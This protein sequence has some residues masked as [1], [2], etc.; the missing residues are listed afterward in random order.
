MIRDLTEQEKWVLEQVKQGEW[1]DLKKRFGESEENRYLSARFLEDLLTDEITVG[2][3]KFQPHRRG[4]KIAHAVLADPLDLENAEVAH[5]VSLNSCIFQKKVNCRD[6]HFT[7]HLFLNDSQF[8]QEAD[9]HRVNVKMNFFFQGAIFQGP[10]DF[11]GADIGRHFSAT[12]AQF[13]GQGPDNKANLNG[14]K[15]GVHAFFNGAVF[16]GPVDFGGADIGGQFFAEGAQFQGQG[17]ENEANFNAM[18]VGQSAF[19]SKAVFQGP[20]DFGNTDIKRQFSADGTQFKG[21]GEDN[22]ANFNAMKVGQSAFFDNAT[23]QGPVDFTTADIDGQFNADGA[24]FQGQGPDNEANFNGVRVGDMVFFDGASFKAG[25]TL[26][27]A[28]VLDLMI[29]YLAEPLPSLSLERTVVSR[30]LALNDITIRTLSASHLEVKVKAAFEGVG[31]HEEADLRD[32]S[33]SVLHLH[34]VT[35][36]QDPEAVLLEGLTYQAVSAGEDPG[37]W[38][39]LLDWLEHSRFN[40]QNYTQ[41]EGYFARCGHQGR[42]DQVFI[43]GKRRAANRLT[44]WKKWFTKILWGG[45]AGYGRKPWQVLYVIVPL[46]VL[47]SVLFPPEFTAKF[48]ESH[49][50]LSNMTSSHPWIIQFLVSLDRFLP[51][52]DLGLAKEWSPSGGCLFTFAY[53]YFLK[54]TGWVTIPIALAAIYTRIK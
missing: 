31:I 50:W 3:E 49:S 15:V 43:A 5:I 47:G 35:W 16:Q 44:W 42:A 36:P 28:R 33:F 17:K 11:G 27:D 20:V 32:S 10:V 54:L 2:S 22:K 18:K 53:W 26:E 39:R 45:L 37:T 1:A 48:K 19:F 25:L 14:L 21:E 41:L 24:Q 7:R 13:Q 30:E 29:R 9:F 38:R 4:I 8:A 46:V 51:G 12:E 23:F 34:G 40:I 52:V 6:A